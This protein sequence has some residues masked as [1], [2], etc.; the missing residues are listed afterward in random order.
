MIIKVLPELQN[1]QQWIEFCQRKHPYCYIQQPEC[2]VDM[3]STYLQISLLQG[4]RHGKE[5]VKYSLGS[6]LSPEPAWKLITACNWQLTTIIAGLAELD[7]NSNVR[8]N[9]LL[10]IHTDLTVRKFY[11]KERRIIPPGS[12]GLLAPLNEPPQ[13]WYAR[14]LL[15]LI[16][17]RQFTDLRNEQLVLPAGD[18]SFATIP[19]PQP[20]QLQMALVNEPRRWRGE[21]DG[22]RLY[23]LRDEQAFASLIP[24]LKKPEPRLKLRRLQPVI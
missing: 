21:R 20:E 14:A 4:V 16:S 23:L 2:L 10:G 6:R 11:A 17:H 15:R 5:A 8:D 3:Q 19:A 22:Q 13:T 9:S 18:D 24:D 1:R 12:I 7:F